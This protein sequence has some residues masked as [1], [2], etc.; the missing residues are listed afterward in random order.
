MSSPLDGT[1]SV[2][3]LGSVI[4]LGLLPAD[5]LPDALL[6]LTDAEARQHLLVACRALV[7]LG[8]TDGPLT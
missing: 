3:I 4:R 7:R 5:Q 8:Q 2:L 6:A 1:E